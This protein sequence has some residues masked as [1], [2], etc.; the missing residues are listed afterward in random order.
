MGEY[1]VSEEEEE[2]DQ[3]SDSLSLE[4]VQRFT[5]YSAM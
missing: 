5:H 1:F 2:Q 3:R 4:E